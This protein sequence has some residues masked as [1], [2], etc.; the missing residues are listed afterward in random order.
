MGKNPL[1]LILRFLLELFGLFALGTWG[2]TQH[3]GFLRFVWAGGLPLVAAILWG[4]FRV[5]NDPGKAP[6]PVPGWVR[7]GL[8]AAYF[9]GAV[10]AL[11]AADRPTWAW[12]FG[13]LVAAHYGLSYDRIAWMLKR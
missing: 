1:N 3:A 12:V 2:W 6:V 11:F 9:G 8:E 4:T 13:L 5:P 7:L 10:L